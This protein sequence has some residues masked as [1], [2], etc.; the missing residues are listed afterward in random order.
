MWELRIPNSILLFEDIP[1][2]FCFWVH[3][4]LK[5]FK[6]T[7]SETSALLRTLWSPWQRWAKVG[8][9]TITCS[10]TT[11]RRPSW[12]VTRWTP[13][14]PLLISLCGWAGHTTARRSRRRW[15]C[16]VST[17]PAMA[18][19]DCGGGVIETS[20]S[21]TCVTWRFPRT[22]NCVAACVALCKL[23]LG[24]D[25]HERLQHYCSLCM[26]GIYLS[27][28]KAIVWCRPVMQFC[29]K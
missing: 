28:D 1:R 19:T 16:V 6:Y 5:F 13:P 8:T 25:L 27:A 23:S 2:Y 11:T 18:V 29:I 17:V 21:R 9:I 22:S 14:L 20:Q 26:W 7:L 24:E 4:F 3:W 10:L 12:A 15:S